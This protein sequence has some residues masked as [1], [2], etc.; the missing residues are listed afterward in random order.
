[1]KA[2][3]PIGRPAVFDGERELFQ[4]H[5]FDRLGDEV[6]VCNDE[7]DAAGKLGGDRKRIASAKQCASFSSLPPFRYTFKDQLV[8]AQGT[9]FNVRIAT[10]GTSE[11]DPSL[12]LCDKAALSYNTT[13]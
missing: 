7:V 11:S 3:R 5:D 9:M 2:G 8:L 13:F 6:I 12:M 10:G 4:Q 1:M